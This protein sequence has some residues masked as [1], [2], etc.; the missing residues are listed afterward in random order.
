MIPLRTC[1][2]CILLAVMVCLTLGAQARTFTM[3]DGT[4]VNGQVVKFQNGMII[5]AKDGGGK[6]ILNLNA[7]SEA[8]QAYLRAQF[9]QG[10]QRDEIKGT[11]TA[12]P[13]P[14]PAP[15]APTATG[16]AQPTPQAASAAAASNHPGLKKLRQGSVAPK[17]K[18][19]IQGKAEYLSLDDL[20]GR[21]VVVHFWSTAVQP[22]I[23]EVEG[24]VYLHHKYK[25]RGFEMIGVAMDGNQRR[26]NDVEKSLGVTW[27]M[28]MDENRETIEEWGVT[29]LPTNV[30]IDQN[31]VILKEHISARELQ[32][33]L[34]EQLGPLK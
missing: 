29:A 21:F 27:P 12:K 17:I 30:L 16:A 20:R 32:F 6:A 31:G 10:D 11:A 8:D 2:R 34:A 19:R 22:S 15:E 9:P 28:R 3:N 7:F 25:D 5:L 18:G 1:R 33:L 26:L 24:L 14:Q 13:A 4:Q 23:E